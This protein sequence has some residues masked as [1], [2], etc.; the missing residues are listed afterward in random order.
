MPWWAYCVLA[1]P[2][3]LAAVVA[4]VWID[5]LLGW[6][7]LYAGTRFKWHEATEN[8]DVVIVHLPG[9]MSD[10]LNCLSAVRDRIMTRGSLLEVAYWGETFSSAIYARSIVRKIEEITSTDQCIVLVGSS[11]GGLNALD[12]AKSLKEAGYESLGIVFNDTP[13]GSSYL[14][15]PNKFLSKLVVFLPFGVACNTLLGPILRKLLVPP[16]DENIEDGLDKEVVKREALKNLA[17]WPLS[18]NRDQLLYIHLRRP[19]GADFGRVFKG[20]AYIMGAPARN[21][22]VQQPEAKDRFMDIV[23]EGI[24]DGSTKMEVF[25]VDTPHCAYAESPSR[26]AAALL[27]AIDH[28]LTGN[29][30]A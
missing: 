10:G 30:S 5:G 1:L 27:E 3:L 12:V 23:H 29:R 7:M 25:I 14:K 16:R 24:S 9:V 26:S 6:Y 22:T 4:F 13:P 19:T 20:M 28:V 11:M 17:K 2:A 8:G 15:P 21:E 18:I